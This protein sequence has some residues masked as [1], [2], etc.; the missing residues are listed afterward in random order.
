MRKVTDTRDI[1]W[2]AV[3]NSRGIRLPKTQPGD[4]LFRGGSHAAVSS[5]YENIDPDP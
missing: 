4:P 2:I 3:G 1:K 5:L